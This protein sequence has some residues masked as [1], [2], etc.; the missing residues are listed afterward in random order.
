MSPNQLWP[1]FPTTP[2]LY[3]VNIF[4]IRT[5]IS[6]TLSYFPSLT[7]NIISGVGQKLLF[8]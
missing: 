4:E 2:A 1:N 7:K 8:L 6:F 5:G 3:D